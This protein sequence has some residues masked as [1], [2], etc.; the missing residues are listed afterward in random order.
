[1]FLF[2][3]SLIRGGGIAP[4]AAGSGSRTTNSS[5]STISGG[6]HDDNISNYGRIEGGTFNGGVT[7]WYSGQIYHG[8]FNGNVW[9]DGLIMGGTFK[10][11]VTNYNSSTGVPGI[12]NGTGYKPIFVGKTNY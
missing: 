4:L 2:R 7:N 3:L 6:V 12:A 10:G 5:G 9:N 11:T 1:M 8:I